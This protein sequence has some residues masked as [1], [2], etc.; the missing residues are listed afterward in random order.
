MGLS[1]LPKLSW[2]QAT[3]RGVGGTSTSD[4]NSVTRVFFLKQCRWEKEFQ[5]F[6]LPGFPCE[7]SGTEGYDILCLLNQEIVFVL[8]HSFLHA[9]IESSGVCVLVTEQLAWESPPLTG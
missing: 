3:V 8:G 1:G 9:S 4:K 6:P 2:Q 5:L 7:T